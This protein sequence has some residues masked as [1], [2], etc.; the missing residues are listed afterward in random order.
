MTITHYDATNSHRIPWHTLRGG[1]YA[2]RVLLPFMHEGTRRYIANVAAQVLVLHLDDLVLPLV[3][4]DHPPP[5]TNAYVCSPTTH[6]IDYARRELAIELATQPWAQRVAAPL[7]AALRPLFAATHIEQAVYVNNW[8]LSTNLYPPLAAHRLHALTA[9]LVRHFPQH[10]II[11]R[12][13]NVTLNS[14]LL[15]TLQQQGYRAIFS[16]QVYLHDPH[17]PAYRRRRD[18]KRDLRLARRTPYQWHTAATLSAHDV[19]RL[20]ALYTDL[21]ITKYST[22]NPQ[23]TRPFVLAA[24]H[25]GWLELAALA[26]RGRIDG[27]LGFVVRDGVMTAPLVGYDQRLPPDDGLYRLISMRLYTEATERGVLLN[28]SS[29]AA[30]FK[31]NRGGQPA[32][33]YSMV[34]DR[35]LPPARRLPWALLAALSRR[36]IVPVMQHYGL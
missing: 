19:P 4:V 34:Y 5:I 35:H 36:V 27:V 17:D 24:L 20:H 16:R 32:L 8:L 31:R 28:M 21:Y 1:D 22:Y 18:Y 9:Y 23:F 2:H 11:F 7:L 15:A 29:G 3:R 14:P 30:S 6:Y 33:E 10:S 25:E 12:S 26:Q 13:L